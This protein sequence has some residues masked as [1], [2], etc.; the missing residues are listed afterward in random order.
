MSSVLLV[1]L[2]AALAAC[3]DVRLPS[4]R[5]APP[6]L[7]APWLPTRTLPLGAV[8]GVSDAPTRTT[9]PTPRPRLD[10]PGSQLGVVAQLEAAAA[11]RPVTDL[12][13]SPTGSL[14]AVAAS[15]E[16]V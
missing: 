16:P 12:A 6:L 2:V 8:I 7:E 9:T 4:I 13:F 14:L 15:G 1:P 10:A 3:E 11:R 5:T